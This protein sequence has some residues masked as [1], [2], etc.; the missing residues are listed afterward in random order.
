MPEASDKGSQ[1][2]RND[3]SGI[4]LEQFAKK[5]P[6]DG[7]KEDADSSDKSSQHGKDAVRL[8]AMRMPEASDNGSQPYR[9]ALGCFEM[10]GE[11]DTPHT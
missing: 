10:A 7:C 5:M 8:F 6:K 3:A 2:E 9:N 1:Q 11:G 4:G